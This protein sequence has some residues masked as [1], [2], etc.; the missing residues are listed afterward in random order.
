MKPI[1]TAL[2]F[3]AVIFATTAAVGQ[4]L[5]PPA[6]IASCPSEGCSP[7]NNHDPQLNRLKNLKSSEKP[8][9]DR[10]LTWMIGREK[11]VEDSGYKR[12]GPR[13]VLTNLDEGTEARVVGL[14]LA[15]KQEHGE[16]CN[17]GLD[18]V[19]VTTDN[20]LVLVN[21]KVV[22][23]TL[24]PAN[25]TK[26]QLTAA[27]KKREPKSVTAEFTPRV[28]A[29]GHPNFISELQKEI[30]KTAQGALRVR[31]TGQLMFDSEHFHHLPLKRATQW[32]IHPILKLEYCPKNKICK[33]NGD[34]NWIDLDAAP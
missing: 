26:S 5:C 34:E 11:K 21:P 10:T 27:F 6:D 8:V 20:H 16:S 19:D 14:L 15:V 31:I 32:E 17:C 25:A 22:T 1:G 7:N 28:R 12:G 24:L 33:T 3:V 4:T 2:L 9:I 18:V 23:D 30:N 29:E 13:N